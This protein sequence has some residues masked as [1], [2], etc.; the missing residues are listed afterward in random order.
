MRCQMHFGVV[1]SRAWAVC[2]PECIVCVISFTPP[3]AHLA[4]LDFLPP[5]VA[6]P[7]SEWIRQWEER[8][9]FG[10]ELP[11]IMDF[12]FMTSSWILIK[13][14]WRIQCNPYFGSEAN[15]HREAQTVCVLVGGVLREARN[16]IA[17]TLWESS[18]PLI[19]FA[20]SLLFLE[21]Q[22]GIVAFWLLFQSVLPA[23]PH[24]PP[25]TRKLG[26]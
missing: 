20:T 13:I 11:F 17:L 8:D 23:S 2:S 9:G 21:P 10:R 12:F 6:G 3:T 1:L 25:A 18:M 4:A 5:S 26:R 7:F 14:L 15:S 16:P 24:F 19:S 22:T